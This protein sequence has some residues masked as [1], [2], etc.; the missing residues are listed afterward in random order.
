MVEILNLLSLLLYGDGLSEIF[1]AVSIT[2]IREGYKEKR[3]IEESVTEEDVESDSDDRVNKNET[4]VDRY[5]SQ[6]GSAERESDPA[7]DERVA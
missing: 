4:V 3:R 1:N 7:V 6:T 5:T 2:F